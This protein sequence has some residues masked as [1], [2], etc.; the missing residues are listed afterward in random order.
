MN[1]FHD[2]R[3]V[4]FLRTHAHKD[5]AD[6]TALSIGELT[7][8][9]IRY[10]ELW[11]SDDFLTILRIYANILMYSKSEKNELWRLLKILKKIIDDPELSILAIYKTAKPGRYGSIQR[12]LTR[13]IEDPFA[14]EEISSTVNFFKKLMSVKI[15]EEA[16][17]A[18]V[19]FKV[20]TLK[21]EP[22]P[23]SVISGIM[24]CLCP[25][26]FIVN[27]TKTQKFAEYSDFHKEIL[28]CDSFDCYLEF[29]EVFRSIATILDI[30]DMRKIDLA[31]SRD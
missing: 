13:E 1:N 27:N 4:E 24:T 31:W 12:T 21:M 17:Q 10:R 25:K 7:G 15:F 5:Y 19:E 28:S 9:V 8:I 3:L 20:N 16:S 18:F 22:K 30:D 6:R 2:P 26:F 14:A 23:L 29:N 11:S